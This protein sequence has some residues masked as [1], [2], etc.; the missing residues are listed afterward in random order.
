MTYQRTREIHNLV[1]KAMDYADAL[2]APVAISVV[3]GG[4]HLLAFL[5]HADTKLISC[6]TAVGKARCAILFSRDSSTTLA[7][8]QKNALAFDSFANASD[9]RFVLAEGGYYLEGDDVRLGAGVAGATPDL[10]EQVGRFLRDQ[11]ATLLSGDAGD[12]RASKE[13]G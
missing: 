13:E 8:A 1:G 2:Q 9:V 11:L 4:G 7:I 5:R 12:A 6:T 10:D 3:D